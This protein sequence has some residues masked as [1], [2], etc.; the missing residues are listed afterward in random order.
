MERVGQLLS[1]HRENIP[2]FCRHRIINGVAE[3][4]NGKIMSTPPNCQASETSDKAPG[5][6]HRAN[7]RGKDL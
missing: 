1:R 7:K 5:K 6:A 3:G 4:L 2:T